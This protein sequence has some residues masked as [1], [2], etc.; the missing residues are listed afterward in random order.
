[1]TK[2]A[3]WGE[4]ASVAAEQ[5]GISSALA[6]TQSGSLLEPRGAPQQLQDLAATLPEIFGTLDQECLRRVAERVG[7]ASASQQLSEVLLFSDSCLHVMQ[8]L[9]GRPGVALLAVSPATSSVG[10]VLS[11]VRARAAELEEAE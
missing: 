4:R 3:G 2:A 10:L 5:L 9:L 7:A 8:P 6:S 11:Q 1:M